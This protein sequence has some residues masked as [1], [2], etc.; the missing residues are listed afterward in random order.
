MFFA[1]AWAKQ[2]LVLSPVADARTKV[3]FR[4]IRRLAVPFVMECIWRSVF[5]SV[6]NSRQ[7][8]FDTFLNSILIDRTL[9][10][11]GEVTWMAQVAL[12]LLHLCADKRVGARRQIS[13]IAYLVVVFAVA[14]EV[15][16]YLGVTTTSCLFEV[17][18]ES[19]WTAI[20]AVLMPVGIFVFFQ[21]RRLPKGEVSK[22]AKIFS[23]FC[24]VQGLYNLPYQCLVYVPMYYSRW[25]EDVSNQKTYS[26]FGPGL[27]N[28]ASH[29]VPTRDWKDWESEWLWMSLYFSCAVWSSI[30][31][32]WA[33]RFIAAETILGDRDGAQLP[34]V[35]KGT[36]A[37]HG[38]V[39]PFS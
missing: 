1:Y 27:W 35:E 18:E 9:A 21:L 34:D 12:A 20:Y 28:A 24:F 4:W 5:P 15:N 26:S 19:F 17:I 10:A 11:V 29:R 32:L 25:R 3:Y 8:F 38:R 13:F 7:T 6:Y 23:G 31:L 33:P 2:T 14:G 30:L 36:V 39:A 16:S 22:G 37:D